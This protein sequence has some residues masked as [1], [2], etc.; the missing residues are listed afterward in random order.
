MLIPVSHPRNSDHVSFGI[1]PYRGDID[2][3][4]SPVTFFPALFIYN[5]SSPEHTTV[6]VIMR[7]LT[8]Y[9]EME[10]KG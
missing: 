2:G 1:P 4:M 7:T 6:D 5:L 10:D 3:I 9:N 8:F